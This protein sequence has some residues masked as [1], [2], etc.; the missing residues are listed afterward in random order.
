MNEQ[1]NVIFE[2]KVLPEQDINV[3]KG[4]V[5]K[6]LKVPVSQLETFFSGKP[7]HLKKNIPLNEAEE[8]RTKLEKLGLIVTIS[9]VSA[10]SLSIFPNEVK[11]AE[12]PLNHANDIPKALNVDV[13]SREEFRG[14]MTM[15]DI[16]SCHPFLEFLASM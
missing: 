13:S 5:L 1:Y 3:V 12:K 2:G 9:T 4:R 8:L 11:M 10:L 7:I 6:H 15:L 16:N 14:N